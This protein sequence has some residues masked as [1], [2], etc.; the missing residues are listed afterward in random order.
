MINNRTPSIE[1]KNKKVNGGN[2]SIVN[3]DEMEANLP[4]ILIK[5]SSIENKLAQ[6]AQ[7]AK[8]SQMLLRVLAQPIIMSLLNEVFRSPKQL[9]AYELSDGKRSTR[10]IGKL[11]KRDQKGISI[12]WRE[13]E[14]LGIAEK[15]GI[16]GQFKARYTLLELL[17]VITSKKQESLVQEK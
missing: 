16:K 9:R 7:Q 2:I 17:F 14:K 6:L 10:D 4:N 15:V 8:E 5:L 13:W 3:Q 11:I 12:W 1:R